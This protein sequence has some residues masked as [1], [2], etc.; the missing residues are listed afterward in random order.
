M[1]A[2][3]KYKTEVVYQD[4]NNM[5]V[6]IDGEVWICQRT[7]Y[8]KIPVITICGVKRPIEGKGTTQCQRLR[9]R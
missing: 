6:K 1:K 5:W 4:M 2:K 9:G 8:K 7:P 3:K